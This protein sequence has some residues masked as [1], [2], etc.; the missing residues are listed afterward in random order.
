MTA[1]LRVDLGCAE[2]GVAGFDRYVDLQAHPDIPADKMVVADLTRPWPF[3]DGSITHLR[4]HDIIEHLPDKIFTF[5]EAW[6][7]LEDGATIEIVVPTTE[8][9]GAI[10]DPTHVSLW[11]RH[12]FDYFIAGSPEHNRFARSYGVRAAFRVLSE[13][14]RSYVMS[15]P[16]GDERVV[17][18]HIVL[19]AIKGTGR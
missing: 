19:E 14:K 3:A 7:C 9:V 4:A 12:S 11:C 17:H 10:C 8:G 1:T 6:R 15:Y 18:L 16:S 2:G 13:E 5:N